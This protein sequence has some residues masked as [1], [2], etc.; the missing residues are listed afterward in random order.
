[1]NPFG[2][3]ASV[4]DTKKANLGSKLVTA[5]IE[6]DV[7]AHTRRLEFG[8]LRLTCGSLQSDSAFGVGTER[9]VVRG[10]D[11]PYLPWGTA[12]MSTDKGLKVV[13]A[14][15]FGP[16]RPVSPDCG[17]PATCNVQIGFRSVR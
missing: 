14:T 17:L 1:M 9:E 2:G 4:P 10:P 5:W 13:Y 11:F 8:A 7:P 16:S 12:G 3:L 6:C 15:H